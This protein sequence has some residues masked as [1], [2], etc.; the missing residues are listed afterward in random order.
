VKDV[1]SFLGHAGLYKQFIKD[2]SK[3]ARPMCK[4]LVKE[5]P[6]IFDKECKQ[7]FRALKKIMMSTPVI[8]PPKWGAPFEIMCDVSD[9]AVRAILG[10][11]IGKPNS[12]RRVTQ[13]FHH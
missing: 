5:T 2:F 13:L 1:R 12:E 4:L 7:A 10:Q 6:F 3:I 8:Q 9:Y 11:R